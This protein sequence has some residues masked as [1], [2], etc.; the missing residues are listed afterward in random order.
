MALTY[1]QTVALGSKAPDFNLPDTVSQK[2]ISLK[3]LPQRLSTVV[4]FICNHCPYVRHIEKELA[5]LAKEYQAKNVSFIAISAND[6]TD[7][8][9]DSP[10]HMQK[11]ALECGYTFPYL[12]DGLQTVAKAYGA[13][14]TPEFY[15]FDKNLE[16][17]YHGRFDE[18]SPGKT[19]P[20]TGNDLR[21]ALDAVLNGK[22]APPSHP[23]MGCNIKWKKSL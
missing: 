6:V 20:V 22:P 1:S 17:A 5:A 10:E 4:M 16:L 8:P 15:V 11:K 19:L 18:S 9:E 7:Y 12:Y 23:S 3:E 21:A 2:M 13:E 14:C